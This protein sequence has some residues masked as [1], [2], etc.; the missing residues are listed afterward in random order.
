MAR[1]GSA[2]GQ[3]QAR[4]SLTNMN[5]GD[6]SGK[7]SGRFASQ[8]VDSEHKGPRVSSDASHA[9]SVSTSFL[10]CF[11]I[12]LRMKSVLV[13]RRVVLE[14]KIRRR[15][16][17]VWNSCRERDSGEAGVETGLNCLS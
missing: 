6:F 15:T 9:S 8:G 7:G 10:P 4:S 5:V 12:A 1:D 14:P 13:S 2:V 11:P 17:E 16:G 3:S